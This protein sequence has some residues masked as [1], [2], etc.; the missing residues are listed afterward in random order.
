M[1]VNL[2]NFSL[3]P[4]IEFCDKIVSEND[5]GSNS[6]SCSSSSL[7]AAA[8]SCSL[9]SSPFPSALPSPMVVP[10]SPAGAVAPS[11]SSLPRAH[12]HH[13][14]SPK[15][16]SIRI[17]N[18]TE[19]NVQIRLRANVDLISLPA[20]G[21]LE[22]S[23]FFTPAAILA[24]QSKAEGEAIEPAS[25]SFFFEHYL[26]LDHVALR[27]GLFPYILHNSHSPLL[28]VMFDIKEERSRLLIQIHST[29]GFRNETNFSLLLFGFPLLPSSILWIPLSEVSNCQSLTITV[30]ASSDSLQSFQPSEPIIVPSGLVSPAL[31]SCHSSSS[32]SVAFS[33][34]VIRICLDSFLILHNCLAC[35]YC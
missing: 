8:A 35:I 6:S 22:S 15:H 1:D 28:I 7:S 5:D 10:A 17:S 26:P 13:S 27:P 34:Q 16:F 32:P 33:L 3:Q 30:Q 20:H 23:S 19:L 18:E 25:C 24:S 12:H 21:S 2:S 29:L 14:S 11:S 31:V 4:V 9:V